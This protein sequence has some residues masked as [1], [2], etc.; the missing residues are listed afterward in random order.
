ME[1]Q[2]VRTTEQLTFSL[3]QTLGFEVQLISNKNLA[4]SSYGWQLIDN[5]LSVS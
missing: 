3:R 1:S 2:R 5:I 4:N